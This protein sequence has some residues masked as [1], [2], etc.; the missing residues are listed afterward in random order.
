[1]L[2]PDVEVVPAA[3]GSGSQ[4]TSMDDVT[5]A[6]EL[7]M[8]LLDLKAADPA[9]FSL[10]QVRSIHG[11][12]S[13]AGSQIV[14]LNLTEWDDLQHTWLIDLELSELTPKSAWTK[15]QLDRLD[16]SP[17][18]PGLPSG[19]PFPRR[20]TVKY[21]TR[22]MEE[23]FQAPVLGSKGSKGVD[24]PSVHFNKDSFKLPPSDDPKFEFWGRQGTLDSQITHELLSLEGTLIRS[25]AELFDSLEQT[26][27]NVA[28]HTAITQKLQLFI[29]TNGL[30]LQ[31]NFR[32]QCWSIT[33]ACKAKL[34]IRDVV[35][36]KTKGDTV[37]SEALRGSCFLGSGVFGPV[38][39]DTQSL[40]DAFPSREDS[41]LSFVGNQQFR[42]RGS[43]TTHSK[44]PARKK[45]VYRDI[46]KTA[47]PRQSA[48][49]GVSQTPSSSAQVPTA[50][51]LFHHARPQGPRG[52]KQWKGKGSRH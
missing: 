9:R 31:S 22:A 34:N 17:Y 47:V 21:P 36:V 18:T 16:T 35:L 40:V 46:Y 11:I 33:S 27:Q 4:A 1:M 6:L 23:Y 49:P 20:L 13:R 2:A 3:D 39:S 26:D 43:D 50:Q 51:P 28:V 24:I 19:Y 25:V 38:P 10:E 48:A 32:T 8:T 7:K 5:S 12:V 14:K 15:T 45:V 42:K 41:R 29:H 30:A 44:G 52:K 37:V